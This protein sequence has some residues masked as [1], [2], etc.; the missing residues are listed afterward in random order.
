MALA[1][2]LQRIEEDATV[3]A[4]AILREAEEAAA[5]VRAEAEE[6]AKAHAETV[7]ARA[8]ADAEAAHGAK[9]A[10]ARLTARDNALASKRQLVE[11]VLG[12]VADHL[13]SLPAEEY[14]AFI[15]RKVKSVARAGEALSIGHEDHGRLGLSIAP[16]LSAASVDVQVRG[17][18]AAI[19][20]GV[21]IEGD[22][23]KVEVS[24]RALVYS[25]RE[26]LV[27]LVSE[28]LFGADSV[29]IG[30]AE[31]AD[32]TGHDDEEAT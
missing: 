29:G 32:D 11:R 2:I 24:A 7:L 16:A 25:R 13:A 30:P 15:A 10:V 12:R 4:A 6:R 3:E 8:T 26:R 27:A 1:D 23:V 20:N 17:T 14:A 31:L 9:L 5:A 19:G 18:T 22:R 21:L 28:K